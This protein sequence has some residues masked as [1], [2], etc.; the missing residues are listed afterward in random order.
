MKYVAYVALF[1]VAVTVWMSG[2]A[3]IILSITVAVAL[4]NLYNIVKK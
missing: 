1:A 2:G 4:Y 3:V